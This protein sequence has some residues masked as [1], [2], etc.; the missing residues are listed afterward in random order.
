MSMFNF[1]DA[2]P[3][4]DVTASEACSC[5]GVALISPLDP[6]GNHCA[7]CVVRIRAEVEG[8]FGA[9]GPAQLLL[10]RHREFDDW[11]RRRPV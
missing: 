5:C 6:F 1:G 9:G 3:D 7:A 8:D 2:R 4:V 10:T 11:L